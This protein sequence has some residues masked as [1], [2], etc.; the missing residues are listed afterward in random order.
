MQAADGLRFEG[1]VQHGYDT[2]YNRHNRA[3][4]ASTWVVTVLVRACAAP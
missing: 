1:V 3:E 2:D 4:S